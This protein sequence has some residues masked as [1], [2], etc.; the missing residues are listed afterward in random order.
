MASSSS[1]SS[2]ELDLNEEPKPLF[3]DAPIRYI[4]LIAGSGDDIQEF[5]LN[6]E[7]AKTSGLIKD[8]L[9]LTGFGEEDEEG[10]SLSSSSS[11]KRLEFPD[12]PGP[13]MKIICDHMIYKFRYANV[14][15]TRIPKF[16]GLDEIPSTLG[17]HVVV[18]TNA[19]RC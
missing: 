4:T 8:M 10:S 9:E 6:E 3:S 12:I 18:A 17:L 2:A 13:A 5:T 15:T 11:R 16:T 14:I 7:A 1:S 19:L